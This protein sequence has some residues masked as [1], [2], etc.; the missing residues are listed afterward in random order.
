MNIRKK[1]GLADFYLVTSII[2]FI[3]SFIMMIVL[4]GIID[5][6]SGHSGL[7]LDE[8][9]ALGIVP[10]LVLY[11]LVFGIIMFSISGIFRLLSNIDYTNQLILQNNKDQLEMNRLLVS[12]LI[13]VKRKEK[14]QI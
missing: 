9:L 2:F 6:N 4:I 1:E 5:Q 12:E 8:I 10:K 13:K 11:F 7:S 14:E 3:L